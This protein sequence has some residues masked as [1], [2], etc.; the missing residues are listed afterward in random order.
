MKKK[1]R[2][3]TRMMDGGKYAEGEMTSAERKRKEQKPKD[4][5]EGDNALSSRQWIMKGG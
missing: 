1:M 4:E 5:S 2:E 3:R